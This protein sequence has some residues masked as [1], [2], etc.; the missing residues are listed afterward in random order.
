MSPGP[1]N[2]FGTENDALLADDPRH[3]TLNGY[4]NLACRCEMCRGAN[5]ERHR[6]YIQR[7]RSLGR[8]LGTHGSSAAYESGCRCEACR[9]ANT[10]KSRARRRAH[11]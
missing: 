9:K 11:V 4:C 8:I 5:R 10:A 2:S 7:V 6:E 1:P 3:G